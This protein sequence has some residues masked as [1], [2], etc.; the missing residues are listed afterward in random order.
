MQGQ[1]A[2]KKDLHKQHDGIVLFDYS[3]HS[4]IEYGF[5]NSVDQSECT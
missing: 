3:S 1:E 2:F 5:G 4:T